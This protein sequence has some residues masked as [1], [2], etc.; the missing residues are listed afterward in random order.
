MKPEW[1]TAPLLFICRLH[2]L[3]AP[4]PMASLCPSSILPAE[5]HDQ[6]SLGNHHESKLFAMMKY[7]RV[8]KERRHGNNTQSSEQYADVFALRMSQTHTTVM[9]NLHKS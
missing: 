7:E 1:T 2:A 4:S 6:H 3:Q 5:R 9:T 8:E